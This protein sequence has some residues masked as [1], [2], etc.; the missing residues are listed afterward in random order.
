[1]KLFIICLIA[2]NLVSSKASRLSE[3]VDTKTENNY[4]ATFKNEDGDGF[5]K[6]SGLRGHALL[7][8]QQSE[9]P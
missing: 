9:N 8:K 5:C 4:Q 3:N 1:M 7:Y 6:A 2:V